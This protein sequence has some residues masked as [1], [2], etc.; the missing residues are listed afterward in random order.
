MQFVANYIHPSSAHRAGINLATPG[1]FNPPSLR[2]RGMF[3][4]HGD[5]TMMRARPSRARI[6]PQAIHLASRARN[7]RFCSSTKLDQQPSRRARAER[8][9]YPK[10]SHARNVL[11]HPFRN[12]TVSPEALARAECSASLYLPVSQQAPS[13][14][15]RAER[16]TCRSRPKPIQISRAHARNV[17][18]S[19]TL[20][21]AFVSTNSKTRTR[22]NVPCGDLGVSGPPFRDTR[23]VQDGW[24]A[25]KSA[26]LHHFD[27]K[28]AILPVCKQ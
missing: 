23:M 24:Q 16:S 28:A 21:R 18:I 10:P 9:T 22:R 4:I 20:A 6:S 12:L 5:K 14:R 19:K 25:G 1:L 15:A 27:G 3:R 8:S 26:R 7:V 17:H 11:S 2:A 13:P